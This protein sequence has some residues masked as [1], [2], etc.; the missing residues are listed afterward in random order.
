MFGWEPV[1]SPGDQSAGAYEGGGPVMEPPPTSGRAQFSW[2]LAILIV[3][4]LKAFTE[5]D[6]L[7]ADPQEI[8]VSL[9]SIFSIWFMYKAGQMGANMLTAFMVK[10]GL[11]L[12]GQ[13]ELVKL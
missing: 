11:A 7:S 2:A 1:E 10:N 12:P 6:L 3:I 13:A 5:S 8:K 9:L 4:G